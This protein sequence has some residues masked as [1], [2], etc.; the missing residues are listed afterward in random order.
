MFLDHSDVD[1]VYLHVAPI[2]FRKGING[3][4]S[5]V[6]HSFQ[7]ESGDTNLF[8]FV[9]RQR[10]KVK[11]LYWNRTGFALWQMALEKDKF[12]WPHSSEQEIVI[13]P[14]DLDFLLSG[15]SIT[16]QRPHKNLHPT[17]FY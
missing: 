9:N 11:V 8:A 10:N 2:D 3:L 13:S 15:Y 5:M 17:A 1:N 6:E 4:G 14:Q 7:G 12:K 16:Q